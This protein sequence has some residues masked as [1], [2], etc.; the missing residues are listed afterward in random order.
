MGLRTPGLDISGHRKGIS[1]TRRLGSSVIESGGKD[2]PEDTKDGQRFTDWHSPFR[3]GDRIRGEPEQQCH[4]S[5][6][7]V[8]EI[9]M[10]Y[11]PPLPAS[12]LL[13]P[14]DAVHRFRRMSSTV[15][16]PRWGAPGTPARRS[17]VGGEG[18]WMT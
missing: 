3:G 10:E 16:R 8:S 13:I 2:Q 4:L 7:G 18:C 11:V 1:T 6:G 5:M 17:R 12:S 15:V 14:T 9:L